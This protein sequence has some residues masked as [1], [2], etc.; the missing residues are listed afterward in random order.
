MPK[1]F[2]K[3]RNDHYLPKGYLRGFIDPASPAEEREPL[4]VFDVQR[5]TWRKR[6]PSQIGWEP[7]FYDFVSRQGD[8]VHA[9]EA[10]TPLENNYPPLVQ[11]LSAKGF[12][13]WREH[14]EFLLSYVQM[15]RCRSPLFR[16]Q[17]LAEWR[18]K[19]GARFIEVLPENAVK[20]DSLK[21]RHFSPGAL[22][23][24]AINKMMSEMKNGTTMLESF[25]W[26]LHLAG[27]IDDSFV[28]NDNPL[29][30]WAPDGETFDHHNTVMIFPL[31]WQA[32]LMGRRNPLT[33]SL[34]GIGVREREA[35]RQTYFTAAR[36]FV[37]SARQLA[38]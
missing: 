8:R 30:G 5:R 12:T 34:G 38:L 9:D 14:L 25:H 36:R 31:C 19:R 11:K 26:Q 7:G 16:E 1:Q 15:I 32:C 37:V 35:V 24:G 13:G 33:L 4:C 22:K 6:H 17:F 18:Q 23:E 20:V 28:T 10:F 2:P 21:L 27:S 3:G 29:I